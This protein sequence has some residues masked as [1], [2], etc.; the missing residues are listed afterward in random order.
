VRFSLAF[1]TNA[2]IYEGARASDGV[3]EV[4]SS[5]SCWPSNKNNSLKAWW[6]DC[7]CDHG[8]EG[9]REVTF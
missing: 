3:I 2:L 9:P 6:E 8:I 1:Y 5:H 4:V 7:S